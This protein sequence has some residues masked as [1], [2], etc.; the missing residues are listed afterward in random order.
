MK[1]IVIIV[2]TLIVLVASII[3]IRTF[4]IPHIGVHEPK[5]AIISMEERLEQLNTIPYLSTAPVDSTTINLE[6]V[7]HYDNISAYPG[8]QVYIYDQNPGAKLLDMDGK[9]IHEFIDKRNKPSPWQLLE[10]TSDNHFIVLSLLRSLMKI[11]WHSNIIWETGLSF[12]HDLDVYENK[13]YAIANRKVFYEPVSTE[14]KIVDNLL[15]ILNSEG[16]IHKK[17][18]FMKMFLK[19]AELMKLIKNEN[20]KEYRYGRDAWDLMHTNTIEVVRKDWNYNSKIKFKKGNVLFCMRHLDIIGVVDI[21]KQKVVWHWG[22]GNLDNPH[23]PTILDNGNILIF[24]NGSRRNSSRVIELMPLTGDIKQIYGESEN[25]EFF[26][27]T[28]GSVQRLSNG[29]T[30]IVNSNNGYVFEISSQR[31]KVW[32]FYSYFLDDK[33]NERHALYR[34]PRWTDYDLPSAESI[35]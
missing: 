19:N 4:I 13:I 1:S 34:M 23:S 28:R 11:D 22:P 9:I 35:E 15:V 32:E 12:H 2:S 17:L 5:E 25:E 31:E 21:A 24:D 16:R 29:N 30:L 7:V 26:T 14:E 18:S 27:N 10:R 20:I 8:L 33:K 6:G 3:L